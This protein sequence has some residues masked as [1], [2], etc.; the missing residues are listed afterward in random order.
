MRI[1]LARKED[2]RSISNF[3]EISRRGRGSDPLENVGLQL[4]RSVS[5]GPLLRTIQIGFVILISL[6]TLVSS[7]ANAAD[8]TRSVFIHAACDGKI[9]SATLSSLIET[10]R[11]SQKYQLVRSLDEKAPSANVVLT[12]YMNCTERFDVAAIAFAFGQ[13]KC[14]GSKNCHVAVDGSSIRSA[15][16]DFKVAPECGRALFMA[17]DDYMSNP[18]ASPLKLY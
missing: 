2:A 9:S 14:F 16:C 6:F 8:S 10:I 4:L 12:L 5:W 17:F 15:L 13:A 11:T 18:P 7:V 1:A 3:F